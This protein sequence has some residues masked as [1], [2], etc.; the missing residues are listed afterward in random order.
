MSEPVLPPEAVPPIIRGESEPVGPP[1]S[2]RG[3]VREAFHETAVMGVMLLAV[4]IAA[5]GVAAPFA[6]LGWWLGAFRGN[7]EATWQ[8]AICALFGLLL[9]FSLGV[10]LVSPV[11]DW[12][13][14]HLHIDESGPRL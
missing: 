10:A 3:P 8:G 14:R 6:L 5:G 1:P 11:L 13:M 7:G 2:K 12:L 9:A 4:I